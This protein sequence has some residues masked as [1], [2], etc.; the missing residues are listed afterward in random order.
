MRETRGPPKEPGTSFSKAYLERSTAVPVG[1][2][3]YV[4]WDRVSAGRV[5]MLWILINAGWLAAAA[6]VRSRLWNV[7]WVHRAVSWN[8]LPL[9]VM[10]PCANMIGLFGSPPSLIAGVSDVGPM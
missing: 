3:R 1:L 4:Y 9:E 8:T 7:A 5:V 2:Q 10:S 6:S